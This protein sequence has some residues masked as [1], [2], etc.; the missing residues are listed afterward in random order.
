M[1]GNGE[2]PGQVAILRALQLGDLLCAVPALRSLRR[3][4]PAAHIALIGLP[5]A[6]DFVER[7]SLYLDE[8]I[9]F[10]GYP[11]LPERPVDVAA[12]PG[13]LGELQ[14]RR[15]DLAVQ[16]QGDG[17][18]TNGLTLLFGAR[19][20]AGFC[21][22]GQPPLAAGDFVVYPSARHEIWRLLALVQRLGVPVAGDQIEFPIRRD[23]EGQWGRLKAETGLRAGEYVC[24]HPGARAETRR[25]PIEHF[26][27]VGLAL[28]SRGLRVVVTGD[29]PEEARLAAHL[30]QAMDGR[31][32]SL[33][34]RTPLGVLAALV[35]D[36]R[37]VVCNDT[38]VSHVAAAVRTRSVVIF[39]VTDPKRWAPIDRSLHG[40]VRDGPGAAERALS[41]TEDLLAREGAGAA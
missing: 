18:I 37:L 32:T 41:Q 4:W 27:C 36:A 7:F 30:V 38:G 31:A 15:L 22:A 5:W 6:R 33:A 40:V 8:F 29:G 14:R 12:V 2:Q 24:L 20:V 26:A 35:R 39:R 9:E 3:A 1:F 28:A 17:T 13:F 11:G 25:W 23:E 16:L 21:L 10:P 34:S 19:R